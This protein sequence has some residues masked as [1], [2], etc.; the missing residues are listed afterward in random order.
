MECLPRKCE[1]L[2]SNTRIIKQTKK[3]KNNQKKFQKQKNLFKNVLNS[4]DLK[5]VSHYRQLC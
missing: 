2:S 4:S 3:Q 1:A 5:P